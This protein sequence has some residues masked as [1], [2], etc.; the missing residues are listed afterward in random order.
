MLMHL[1][2]A[3]GSFHA[4]TEICSHVTETIWPAKPKIFTL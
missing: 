3:G 1:P 4:T 2:N